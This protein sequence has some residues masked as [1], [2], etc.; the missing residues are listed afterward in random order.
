MLIKNLI[1]GMATVIQQ[2]VCGTRADSEGVW[3]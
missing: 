1:M 2:E 3:R